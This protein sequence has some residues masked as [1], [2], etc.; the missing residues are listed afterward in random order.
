MGYLFMSTQ[1]QERFKLDWEPGLGAVVYSLDMT[2]YLK[3]LPA[4][5][6]G[7]ASDEQMAEYKKARSK[8]SRMVT[9]LAGELMWSE[10]ESA[11][12]K[13]GINIKDKSGEQTMVSFALTRSCTELVKNSMDAL[14]SNYLKDQSKTTHLK[15]HFVPE[16]VDDRLFFTIEDNGGGFPDSAIATYNGALGEASLDDYQEALLTARSAKGGSTYLF[17][18]QGAGLKML[19]SVIR[20]GYSIGR[21]GEFPEF[22]MDGVVSSMTL[23]NGSSGAKISMDTP[24]VPPAR[25]DAYASSSSD[26]EPVFLLDESSLL[27]RR[28]GKRSS[29]EKPSLIIEDGEPSGEVVTLDGMPAA[30]RMRLSIFESPPR[31]PK[32]TMTDVA[33]KKPLSI[34]VADEED[35]DEILDH[36]STRDLKL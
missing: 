33:H 10:I 24:L 36:E 30:A 9:G 11:F 34:E 18:G 23:S 29:V 7:T 26:E 8:L 31:A 13:Q 4:I 25:V 27:A 22:N 35:D 5:V 14:I 1:L 2:P 17:G 20:Y 16:E 19:G 6:A 12:A 15:I 28:R 32:P 3:H 21:D